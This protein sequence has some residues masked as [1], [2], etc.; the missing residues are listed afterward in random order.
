ML[1]SCKFDFKQPLFIFYKI[2]NLTEKN[3]RF[4]ENLSVRLKN[5]HLIERCQYDKCTSIWWKLTFNFLG[6]GAVAFPIDSLARTHHRCTLFLETFL[7]LSVGKNLKIEVLIVVRPFSFICVILPIK[8]SSVDNVLSS[9]NW[10]DYLF[11]FGKEEGKTLLANKK[12]K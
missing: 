5:V 1:E 3:C 8:F 12:L 9:G 11:N 4:I 10:G 7:G 2:I 6:E